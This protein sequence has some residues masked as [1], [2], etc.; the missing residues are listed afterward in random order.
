MPQR[1][2][3]LLCGEMRHSGSSWCV[4]MTIK[5]M[6]IKGFEESLSSAS[7]AGTKVT[8]M[9]LSLACKYHQKLHGELLDAEQIRDVY[10]LDFVEDD[11]K[12]AIV[13]VQVDRWGVP[14]IPRVVEK[15]RSQRKK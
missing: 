1:G 10:G 3:E 15:A 5:E 8:T 4:L 9:C 7:R 2:E 11:C 13:L 12:C 14:L 6:R